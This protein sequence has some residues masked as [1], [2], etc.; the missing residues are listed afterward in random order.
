[1]SAFTKAVS[2]ETCKSEITKQHNQLLVIDPKIEIAGVI[3]PL[4]DEVAPIGV[5][6]PEQV[7]TEMPAIEG[8]GAG[9]DE[10]AA[11]I[12]AS[13]AGMD[14]ESIVVNRYSKQTDSA[15]DPVTL[16]KIA[17]ELRAPSERFIEAI[18]TI[19]DAYR[20]NGG[21]KAGKEAI[22]SLKSNLPAVT[23]NASG[24]RNQPESAN[25][26]VAVDLD[27]LGGRIETA[28]SQ[29]KLDS[30][31]LLV[32][33]SPSGDGLKALFRVPAPS[34][35]ESE[36]R[37]AH[38]RNFLAVQ[39][40]L[41]KNYGLDVDPAASDLMRLCYLSHDPHC[42]LNHAA[43]ELDINGNLPADGSDPDDVRWTPKIGPAV[44]R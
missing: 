36:M 22:R 1:M 21:G 43:V 16:V 33:K 40:Y 8:G 37:R 28:R 18:H 15:G 27:E 5:P 32:F 44:K 20:V 7:T 35:T 13:E 3:S 25:G 24:S 29:L 14:F 34:G 23:F 11:E 42:K 38:R 2:S 10:E 6:L 41:K 17:E 30:H 31:C 4:S 19:R 26:I 12:A 39:S 9:A